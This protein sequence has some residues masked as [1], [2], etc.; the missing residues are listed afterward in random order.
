MRKILFIV[1]FLLIY[2]ICFAQTTDFTAETDPE[3]VG[4]DTAQQKLIDITVTKFEDAAFWYATMPRDQGIITIRRLSG[5]PL[6]KEVQDKERLLSEAELNIPPGGYVLGAKVVFNKRGMNHFYIYPMQPLAIEGIC[7]T[8][9]VWVAGRNFNHT[10]K[11]VILDYFGERKELIVSKLNFSGWQK[12]TVAIPPNIAQTDFHYTSKNG[13]K[14][15]GFKI[16][17]D[18]E[19]SVGTYYIYF[20]DL[21]AV[22]DLFMETVMEKDDMKDNW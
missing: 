3:M 8:I 10:L 16:E 11:I 21:S 9:S 1:S 7:K 5:T 14:F 4:Q 18:M 19:E 13:I 20:D 17:C 6:D 12:L 22:T 2:F 15:L